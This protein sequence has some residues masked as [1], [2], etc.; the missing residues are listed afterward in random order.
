MLANLLSRKN[1]KNV[2]VACPSR[3]PGRSLPA[4]DRPPRLDVRKLDTSAKV[5]RG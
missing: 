1:K 3:T 5:P 2:R 4:S